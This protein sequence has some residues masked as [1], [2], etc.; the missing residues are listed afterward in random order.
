MSLITLN[1]ICED[2]YT[3]YLTMLISWLVFNGTFSTS[4][5]YRTIVVSNILFTGRIQKIITQIIHIT[6]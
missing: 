4:K 1:F 2:K 6:L 3:D 5:L